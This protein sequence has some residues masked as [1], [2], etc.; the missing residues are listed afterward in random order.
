MKSSRI[1]HRSHKKNR[2]NGQKIA[3]FGAK[4][5]EKD[6]LTKY[7]I[8]YM[9]GI[10]L[11]LEENMRIQL[12]DHFTYGRLMRFVLPSIVM[13]IFTSV[14]SVVDGLFVSNFVGKTPFA[15]LNLIY[16]FIMILGAMGFM[17]GTGGSALVSKTLGEGDEELANR[18]FSM[19]VYVTIVGGII[20]AVV[21]FI[22]V[23]Q[24]ALWFGAEGDMIDYCVL[25]GRILLVSLPVFMLQ[26]VFQSF[27]VTA[28]KPGLGLA[29]MIAAGMTNIVMDFV[30]IVPCGLGLAGAAIATSLSQVIG[31]LI[32]VFYFAR[33][34]DSLLRLTKTRFE[35][36]V[37]LRTCTNGSSELMTNISMSIMSILYNLQLMKIAGENGVSAYGVVV[38]VN[39][40]FIAIFLGYSIGVAPIIGY[41]YGAKNHSELKNMLRKSLVM[42]SIS[43]VLLT[44]IAELFSGQLSAIFVGYDEELLEM[45]VHGMR[46]YSLSYLVN[47]FNVFG[48]AFFTALNNGAISAA[49]SFLRTLLFQIAAV[50]I[51]PIFLGIDGLWLAIVVAELLA[52]VVTVIFLVTQR[53]RYGYA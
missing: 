2:A 52:L 31:G 3:Y 9:I 44:V 48:S 47:G 51:L 41:N 22:N 5:T 43:C 23:R 53:K 13:M 11:L 28:Q 16:P 45:T 39:F 26:N 8:P 30:L 10:L 12:S 35:G 46:L 32:P 37:L 42:V 20:I 38:Y 4:Y 34:N 33:R 14:Y 18:R 29:I 19:L 27:F 7:N 17:I 36:L 21:G 25:Y 49:I 15:A 1:I 24:V 50:F 6:R 40:V